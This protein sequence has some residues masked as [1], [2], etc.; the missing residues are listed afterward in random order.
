MLLKSKRTIIKQKQELE[1][2]V[3]ENKETIR[4]LVLDLQDYKEE[5]A[6]L[7]EDNINYRQTLRKI[8]EESKKQ[9]YGSVENLQAKIKELASTAINN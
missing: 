7:R 4:N 3:A 6:D 9:Q 5:N 8:L 1:R 2:I